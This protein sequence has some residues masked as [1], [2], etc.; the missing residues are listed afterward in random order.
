MALDIANL[1]TIGDVKENIIG[2]K[3]N[4]VYM[5]STVERINRHLSDDGKSLMLQ[6]WLA[7]TSSYAESIFTSGGLDTAVLRQRYGVT[8][9]STSSLRQARLSTNRESGYTNTSQL[10]IR[11]SISDEIN[12]PDNAKKQW[13]K[14]IARP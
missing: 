5:K 12:H 13:E 6:R 3:D 7:D 9:E 14:G 11:E 8:P 1:I 2:I 10:D 4:T